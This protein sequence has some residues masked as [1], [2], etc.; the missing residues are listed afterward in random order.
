MW[1]NKIKMISNVYLKKQK[2]TKKLFTTI[3]FCG[4]INVEWG[5]LYIFLLYI[6]AK[7][8]CFIYYI[9]LNIY[10]EIK[11][12]KILKLAKKVKFF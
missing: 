5:D 2:F 12:I 10:I 4:I 1:V 3:Y 6:S 8:I 11:Y 7:L 9:N